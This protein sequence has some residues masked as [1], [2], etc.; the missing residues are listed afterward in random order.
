M[1]FAVAIVA[2]Q[3][4]IA[5]RMVGFNYDLIITCLNEKLAVFC[6]L[7][8]WREHLE[9]DTTVLFVLQVMSQ[10]NVF[11]VISY[12]IFTISSIGALFDNK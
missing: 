11:G 5:K 7:M 1:H 9:D 4:L 3:L 2:Y 8:I 12:F 6:E 10:L